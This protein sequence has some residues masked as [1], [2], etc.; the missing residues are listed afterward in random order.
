MTEAAWQSLKDR[1]YL[2]CDDE[3]LGS[4][5]YLKAYRWMMQQMHV[6]LGPPQENVKLPL[7]AWYQYEGKRK[8]PIAKKYHLP[9]R[10]KGYRVECHIPDERVLLSDFVL[11][12]QVLNNG[13]LPANRADDEAFE[14]EFDHIPQDSPERQAERQRVIEASWQR[15]FDLDWYDDYIC[16]RRD[17]QA[18]QA[19]FWR[20]DMEQVRR[21]DAF[22]AR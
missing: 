16:S 17:Q 21:V 11:W 22:V 15:I 18:I 19:C 4:V 10:H 5:D 20:L 8:K 14:Q 12:H 6:R 7:W 3:A 9:K 13:Y 2:I 1:G